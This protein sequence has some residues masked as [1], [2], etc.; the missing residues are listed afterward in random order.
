MRFVD[1]QQE[2]V[3]IIANRICNGLPKRK[4]A[5]ISAFLRQQFMRFAL[6]LCHANESESYRSACAKPPA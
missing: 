4:S 2:I 1:D 3:A 5:P 6:V